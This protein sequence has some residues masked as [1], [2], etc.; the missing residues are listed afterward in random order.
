VPTEAPTTLGASK[1]HG[2]RLPGPA[3]TVLCARPTS[4]TSRCARPTWSMSS[5]RSRATP[6]STPST[7]RTACCSTPSCA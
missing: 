2:T 7:H 6:C 1:G 4:P 5:L 3:A